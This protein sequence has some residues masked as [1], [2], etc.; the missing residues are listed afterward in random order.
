MM[1]FKT[2]ESKAVNGGIQYKA[3][4]DNGYGV[5]IVKHSFSYGGELGLWELAVLKGDANKWTLCYDTPITGDVMGYLEEDEV[6]KI[7]NDVKE[8][9]DEIA[10]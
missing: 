6:N 9:K 2:F 4:F 7:V 10:S 3:F 1:D 5:S 8:L